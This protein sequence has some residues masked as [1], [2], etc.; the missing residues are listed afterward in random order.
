MLVRDFMTEIYPTVSCVIS[1]TPED[2]FLWPNDKMRVISQ[3]SLFSWP[4][5]PDIAMPPTV[6]TYQMHIFGLGCVLIL[7]TESHYIYFWWK[8]SWEGN[9]SVLPCANDSLDLLSFPSCIK[10]CKLMCRAVAY[11]EAACL[12]LIPRKKN[13]VF[14]GCKTFSNASINPGG[15]MGQCLMVLV[16]FSWHRTR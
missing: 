1:I 16:W 3:V 14:A 13:R 15:M 6:Y 2:P 4:N 7:Y 11:D 9:A 5:P 10:N 8:G 12:S